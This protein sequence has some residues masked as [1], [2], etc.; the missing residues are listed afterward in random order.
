MIAKVS[1]KPFPGVRVEDT[2]DSR[3][4]NL[5]SPDAT[6]ASASTAL[7]AVRLAP[8]PSHFTARLGFMSSLLAK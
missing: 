8:S 7:L 3:L 1:T 4:P 6:K 5:C 2:A